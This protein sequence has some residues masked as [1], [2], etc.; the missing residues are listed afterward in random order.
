MRFIIDRIYEVADKKIRIFLAL[1][2]HTHQVFSILEAV[3][4]DLAYL[5]VD[6]KAKRKSY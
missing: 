1:L 2:L 4:N 6:V 5:Y 3:L